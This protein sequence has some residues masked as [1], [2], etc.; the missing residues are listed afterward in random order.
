MKF[1][2]NTPFVSEQFVMA[3]FTTNRHNIDKFI[4]KLKYRGQWHSPIN[5]GFEETV[6][7]NTSEDGKAM[8][9]Y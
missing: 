5:L 8:H 4:C 9:G 2:N 3:N 6:T 7:C 1:V